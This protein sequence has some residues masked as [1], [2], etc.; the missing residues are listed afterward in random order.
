M[1]KNAVMCL[2]IKITAQKVMIPYSSFRCL[3]N[4]KIGNYGMGSHTL[5]T[6]F[7]ETSVK[8]SLFL[9][10]LLHAVHAYSRHYA[11]FSFSIC[12][13]TSNDRYNLTKKTL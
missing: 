10:G 11:Y 7:Y 4:R 13:L 12:K 1:A 9:V 5:D 8:C 2:C 6:S 3:E